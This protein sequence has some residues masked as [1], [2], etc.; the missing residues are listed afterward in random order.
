L[1]CFNIVG[2][3]SLNHAIILY[4]LFSLLGLYVTTSRLQSN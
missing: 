4:I 2:M 1:L 3:H